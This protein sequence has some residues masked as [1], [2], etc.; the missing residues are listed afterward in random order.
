MKKETRLLTMEQFE[1]MIELSQFAFQYEIPAAKLAESKERFGQEE[2]DRW[3]IYVEDRLAAQLA[4]LDL[5]TYIGGKRYAMGGIAGVSTWPEY[6]RQGLVAELLHHSL[7][8]MKEK[9]QTLSFLHPFLI[10]FYR[11][12]GWEVY[13]DLKTYRIDTNMLPARSQY[14]GTMKR[15]EI[16]YELLNPI[17]N[18][19]ARLVNG[20]LDRSE[21]WWKYRI[22]SRKKGQTV[23]YY[24]ATGEAQGYVIYEVKNREL[25]VHELIDLNEEAR[26]SLW[27]F[28]GQHDSMI[29]QLVIKVA[30]DDGLPYLLNNP[31]IKQEIEPYF[32]ARIVDAEA[33]LKEYPFAV[34]GED[35]ET[36]IILDIQDEHAPWNEGQ[37]ELRISVD[38]KANVQRI[39]GETNS[40]RIRMG[41][42]SLAAIL[43]GYKRPTELLRYGLIQGELDSV[44]QIERRIPVRTTFLPDFF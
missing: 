11:K 28:L 9:G 38:G 43:T 3:G 37:Y 5:Y 42:G 20:A 31:R 25:F 34:V 33:F 32:M 36:S 2:T 21:A 7:E 4:I 44:E 14:N 18:E 13:T 19:Y 29:D 27:S 16:S 10:S 6:R 35:G 15:V 40:K 22:T 30:T 8:Q 12:F 26:R 41:I 1:D 23:V 39:S 24:D 17:Y